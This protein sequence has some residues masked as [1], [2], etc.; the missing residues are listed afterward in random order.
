MLLNSM[1]KEKKK[2]H[3]DKL[4]ADSYIYP[5]FQACYE[6]VVQE[7]WMVGKTDAFCTLDV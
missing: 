6:Y 2:K 7:T 1:S 5:G 3:T 4:V